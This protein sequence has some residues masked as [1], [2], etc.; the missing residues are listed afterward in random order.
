MKKLDISISKA[1]LMRFV[2]SFSED[3]RP[4]VSA[5]IALLTEENK[6]V[7]D[8]DISTLSWQEDHKFEM[9]LEMINPIKKIASA[10]EHVIIEHLRVGQLALPERI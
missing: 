9:P 7:A 10:L 6:H 1:Q 5:T 4:S 2:V 3:M 8:F